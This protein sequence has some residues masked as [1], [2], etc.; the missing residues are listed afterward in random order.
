MI[1]L[2]LLAA[3]AGTGLVLATVPASFNWSPANLTSRLFVSVDRA[4][5]AM[6][7]PLTAR[8]VAGVNRRVNRRAHRRDYSYGTGAASYVVGAAASYYNTPSGVPF[9]GTYYSPSAGSSYIA[10][11]VA[12][13]VTGRQ[14]TI[15]PSG[16]LWC[17]TP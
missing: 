11:A 9:T 10:A 3:S 17:W 6:G 13:V 1:K 16:Y 5:A 15:S 12:P 7:R 14:C 4:E 2:S 8:S